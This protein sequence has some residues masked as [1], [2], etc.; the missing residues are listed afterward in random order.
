MEYQ[1]ASIF[2]KNKNVKTLQEKIDSLQG[3]ILKVKFENTNL[4]K[5]GM[6]TDVIMDKLKH[7]NFFNEARYRD[8]FHKAKIQQVKIKHKINT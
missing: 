7:K 5:D 6:K 3:E 2:R 8:A 4:R 1:M